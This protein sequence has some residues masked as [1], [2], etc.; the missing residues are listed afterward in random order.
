MYITCDNSRLEITKDMEIICEF[1]TK[2]AGERSWEYKAIE[3]SLILL[4]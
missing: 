2:K 4:R 3:L 1:F